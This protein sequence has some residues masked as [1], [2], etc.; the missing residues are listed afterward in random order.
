MDAPRGPF[1]S[2]TRCAERSRRGGAKAE[3]CGK[4]TWTLDPAVLLYLSKL[5]LEALVLE[6]CLF[7]LS[8]LRNHPCLRI[9]L[10]LRRRQRRRRL[11]LAHLL[12]RGMV[13]REGSVWGA[14]RSVLAR[15]ECIL[16]RG[17]PRLC[18]LPGACCSAICTRSASSLCE[19]A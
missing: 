2:A 10:Q 15:G 19:R 9:C 3:F 13:F 6:L 1:L 12:P 14:C 7:Y 17:T 4:S 16:L 18:P 5:I 8:L 11:R